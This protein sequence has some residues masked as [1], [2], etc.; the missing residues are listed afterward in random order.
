MRVELPQG[1]FA[2]ASG[3]DSIVWLAF[4]SQVSSIV[5]AMTLSGTTVNRPVKFL[6]IGRN[7]FDTTL[8]FMIWYNGTIW[9]N[10][11]GVGV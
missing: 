3:E 11:S 2:G 10:A 5:T 4:F 8:G 9:V 6:W 1:N 7:Y